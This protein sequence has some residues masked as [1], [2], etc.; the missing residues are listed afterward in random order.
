MN[1]LTQFTRT[2]LGTL[3][4]EIN[5]ELA[6]IGKKF[7]LEISIGGGRFSDTN[8]KTKLTADIIP[9]E[10][11]TSV[12]QH[13]FE[14]ECWKVGLKK[15]DFGKTF[16]THQGTFKIIGLKTRSW[17]F[18]VIAENVKNGKSFKFP[19]AVVKRNLQ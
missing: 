9:S 10:E 5:V 4:K 7:G 14:N 18:P 6:K 16:T 15:S 12:A 19:E 2:N 8:F 17:K 11:G 1:K 3:E 13:N